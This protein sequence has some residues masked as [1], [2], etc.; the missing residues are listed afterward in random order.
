MSFLRV[1][2]RTVSRPRVAVAIPRSASLV[3]P[4]AFALQHAAYSAAAGLSNT[5]IKQRVLDVL[6]SFEKVDPSKLSTSASFA[7]DLGLDSLDTVEVVMAV[8][9]EFAI[10]IPDAEA[11]DIKTVQQAIDYIAKT[12]DGP[13][14]DKSTSILHFVDIV[15]NQVLH[16]NTITSELTVDQFDEPVSCLALR[17]NSQGLAC[18]AAQGF[19]LIDPS[20]HKL[21]YI[22]KILPAQHAAHVRFNDGA[23][24]SQGRFFAGTTCSVDPYIPGQLYRYDPGTG[25]ATLVDEGPFTDCNGLGWS[26]DEKTM[27]LTDSLV[28]RIYAYDYDKIQGKP[29]NRRIFI[30]T[31][32]QGLPKG[33]FPDGLCISDECIWSA[34]WG[35]SK[36]VRHAKDGSIDFEIHF[37]TALNI[38]ACCFGGPGNDQ[39]YVTTA[40]CGANGGDAS[41]QERYP[42]SGDVFKVDLSGRF[43]GG[44]W[45]YNFAH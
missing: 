38:T 5:V 3:R 12:P 4:S 28:N 39:L 23:C 37:P 31:L 20:T 33:T 24:D 44:D 32:A 19:A 26:A 8:E 14:Y 10:E 13:L 43:K 35:G 16:F 40:H 36:V 29:S 27:Y 7:E 25:A 18:A 30:D 41:R 1:A 21:S 42:H 2:L 9:E 45:R 11:D 17:P 34:R 6:K 22:S 15:K